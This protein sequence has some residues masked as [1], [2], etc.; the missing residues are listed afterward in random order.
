MQSGAGISDD[1][2][3]AAEEAY[4]VERVPAGDEFWHHQIVEIEPTEVDLDDLARSGLDAL[5]RIVDPI[6]LRD[7]A[8]R[9]YRLG[10]PFLA[11]PL[12]LLNGVR[13]GTV[14]DPMGPQ[15]F[16]R[17][18]LV[19]QDH[20]GKEADLDFFSAA[21]FV[22]EVAVLGNSLKEIESLGPEA[23]NKLANI[24]HMPD[25]M[26]TSTV[27]ELL[28]GAAAVRRGNALE[29]LPENR[30]QKVPDYRL[31]GFGVPCTIECKRRLGLTKYEL[32][33][34]QLVEILY[35]TVREPLRK[36]GLHLSIEASFR[37]P[38]A[39]VDP[40]V[41]HRDVIA[42]S[43]S[44]RGQDTAETTW[45]SL[46]VH[47]L[48]FW[49][50][51]SGTRLYSPDFLTETFGWS[52]TQT[53]WDGLVCEVESPEEIIVERFKRPLCLKWRSESEE[54]LVKKARGVTSLWADAV[55]QIPDG[56]IGFVYIAYPEGSRAA[57]ADTRTRHILDYMGK[58]A[59]HHWSVIVPVTVIC[60]LFARAVGGGRPDLIENCLP[61]AQTGDE[62]WLTK[63]PL[64]VFTSY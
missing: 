50:R 62:F 12:H 51:M 22:P 10:T 3:R 9:P 1:E 40:A 24:H 46:A 41:F 4:Q 15:R 7:Q 56:E 14:S 36:I 23:L 32:K 8:Q 33:E 58:E 52:P 48:Q 61:G 5:L 2:V 30:K 54:A 28:V 45:G 34:G 43:R 27:F 63:L 25:D 49:G 18:L 11:Q 17:M 13:I 47:Q 53:D 6:W 20:L 44:Q 60:R 19:C 57:I 38:V 37:V 29:M 39:S 26:V 31:H 16:A 42:A 35:E 59:W 64:R 21:S 55:R